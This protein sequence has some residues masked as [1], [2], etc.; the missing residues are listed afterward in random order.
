MK[1]T[2]FCDKG[3]TRAFIS[4]FIC[5]L[6]NCSSC[7][8]IRLLRNECEHPIPFQH[9]FLII[10]SSWLIILLRLLF[11]VFLLLALLFLFLLFFFF[12][13]LSFLFLFFLWLFVAT[14]LVRPL[15]IAYLILLRVGT[16]ILSF[17]ILSEFVFTREFITTSHAKVTFIPC[18][19]LLLIMC[20]IFSLF[21]ILILFLELPLFIVCLEE[22]DY[23]LAYMWDILQFFVV[24][25]NVTEWVICSFDLLLRC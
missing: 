2:W 19:R 23:S 9:T 6:K 8:L 5:F 12:L 7:L 22:I 10:W 14:K 25:L 1:Y 20:L 3:K 17:W 4:S 18:Q 11:L 15:C 21:V 24:G 13:L 16:L